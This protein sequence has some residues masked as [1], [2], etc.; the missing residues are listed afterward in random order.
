MN[1]LELKQLLS[2]I[3]DNAM[4][5]IEADHGQQSEQAGRILVTDEEFENDKFPYYG[6]ELDWIGIEELYDANNITAV[7]IL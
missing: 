1:A 2:N 5:Y 7:L 3:P 4:I 6:E